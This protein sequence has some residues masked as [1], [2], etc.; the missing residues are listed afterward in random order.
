M[1]H[2]QESERN[3]MRRKLLAVIG[4]IVLLATSVTPG[5]ASMSRPA[6]TGPAV[7]DAS[8][9]ANPTDESKVPHYFGPYPTGRTAR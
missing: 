4:A 9:P 8:P 7:R 6:M 1:P 2:R 5:L 3:V